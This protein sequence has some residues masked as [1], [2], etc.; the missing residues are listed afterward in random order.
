M[1]SKAFTT[2]TEAGQQG[3][4]Q[5]QISSGFQ[6][7]DNIV[8]VTD[9]GAVSAAVDLGTGAFDLSRQISSDAVKAN[10]T[11]LG[12]SAGLFGKFADTLS[13][14]ANRA[15]DLA[16]RSGQALVNLVSKQ[17][18]GETVTADTRR[19]WIPYAFGIAALF[20]AFLILRPSKKT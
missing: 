13:A 9:S 7:G 6:V 2:G 20:I 8:T 18:T 19:A 5:T 14:T 3:Q 17:T 11:F 15:N 10:D 16:E 12:T 4:D 1:G